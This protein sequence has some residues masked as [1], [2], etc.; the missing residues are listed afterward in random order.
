MNPGHA[1]PTMYYSDVGC[2]KSQRLLEA[3]PGA[4]FLENVMPID[5]ETFLKEHARANSYCYALEQI[6]KIVDTSDEYNDDLDQIAS[7]AMSALEQYPIKVIWEE[8]DG[9]SEK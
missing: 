6:I 4:T 9:V 2:L 1:A 8:D 5:N 3:A 7:I